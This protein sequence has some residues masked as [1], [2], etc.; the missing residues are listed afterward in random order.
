M[1]GHKSDVVALGYP[2]SNGKEPKPSAATQL[3]ELAAELYDFIAGEDGTP[4]AVGIDS[5]IAVP[6]EEGRSSLRSQLAA[7]FH[8]RHGKAA[9]RNALSEAMEVIRGQASTAERVSV[10]LRTAKNLTTGT[11]CSTW[12]TTANDSSSSSPNRR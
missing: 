7:T 1:N 8:E 6:I 4:Y 10:N 3:V 12:A 9:S 11:C 2:S 5:S